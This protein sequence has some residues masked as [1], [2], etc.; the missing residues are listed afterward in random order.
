MDTF[1][2]IVHDAEEGGYWA[3]VPSLPGCF[4][5]GET[6]DELRANIIEAIQI[7]RDAKQEDEGASPD[8]AS[9]MWTLTVPQNRGGM[10]PA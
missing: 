7:C 6:L 2:V 9:F 1:A 5:Q 3:E 4:S 8:E 10:V